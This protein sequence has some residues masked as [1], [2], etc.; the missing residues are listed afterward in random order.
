MEYIMEH[1]RG[2]SVLWN[3]IILVILIDLRPFDLRSFVLRPL[4]LCSFVPPPF[5]LALICFALFRLARF[6]PALLWRRAFVLRAYVG[7][8]KL[9]IGLK[10]RGFQSS[11]FAEINFAVGQKSSELRGMKFRGWQ[12]IFIFAGIKFHD[13][14]KK[15]AK[16]RN[17][18]AKIS[19]NKVR[20]GD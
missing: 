16:P 10:F 8:Q 5:C 2:E 17:F 14:A 13:S 18:P 15:I 11:N 4:V 6:C 9:S 1:I 7:E 19:D 20:Q 3:I 12:K